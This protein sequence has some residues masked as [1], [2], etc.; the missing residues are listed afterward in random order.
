[1]LL[2]IQELVHP[3]QRLQALGEGASPLCI[4]VA[5]PWEGEI[6]FIIMGETPHFHF[7]LGPHIMFSAFCRCSI[8]KE[9]IER[10]QGEKAREDNV[11][12]EED[13]FCKDWALH[14]KSQP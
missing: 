4:G 12:V 9:L 7:A 6:D 3:E 8:K 10:L 14:Q 1:M 5:C 13:S 2:L 11:K